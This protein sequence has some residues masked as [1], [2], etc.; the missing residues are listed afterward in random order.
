MDY[1]PD[2]TTVMTFSSTITGLSTVT[3]LC[4][5]NGIIK[6]KG[7]QW[8]SQICLF[9]NKCPS[10][11]AVIFLFYSTNLTEISGSFLGKQNY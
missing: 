6:P 1:L 5:H 9:F 10:S 2:L 8:V 7:D 4:V 11:Q 3:F